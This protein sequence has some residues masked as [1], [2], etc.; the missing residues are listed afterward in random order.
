MKRLDGI[1][2]P[3]KR[4]TYTWTVMINDLIEEHHAA[5]DFC[6]NTYTIRCTLCGACPM[7]PNC[8]NAGCLDSQSNQEEA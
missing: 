5:C 7:T 2:A 6:R 4:K 8:N 3:S 1:F